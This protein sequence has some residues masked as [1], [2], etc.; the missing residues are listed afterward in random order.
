LELLDPLDGVAMPVKK[1]FMVD[2]K[3]SL[4]YTTHAIII[5]F[6]ALQQLA[7]ELPSRLGDADL[8]MIASVLA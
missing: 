7:I 2:T 4:Q 5:L 8:V 1:P 6:G 3:S